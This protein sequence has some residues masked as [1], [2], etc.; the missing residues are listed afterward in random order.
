[1]KNFIL[2]L[3]I[4]LSPFYALKGF[5][6]SNEISLK[7][8]EHLMTLN[9]LGIDDFLFLKGYKLVSNENFGLKK[10]IKYSKGENVND[11][12]EVII[13]R[14]AQDIKY[15]IGFIT[16]NETKYDKL[17][18]SIIESGY[19]R[20]PDYED[21][22]SYANSKYRLDLISLKDDSGDLKYSVMLESKT[23]K[24]PL[25]IHILNEH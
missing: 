8:I 23:V 10:S 21:F 2:L 22:I 19:K 16:Y 14:N 25:L 3:T 5:S 7:N 9:K 24:N 12:S 4:F 18:K 13:N 15:S 1:M 20:L 6:Q 11:Y 17:R